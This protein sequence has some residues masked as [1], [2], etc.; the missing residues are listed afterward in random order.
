MFV[1]A[2]RPHGSVRSTPNLESKFESSAAQ[3]GTG[4]S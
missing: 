2:P 3:M 1:E 4:E